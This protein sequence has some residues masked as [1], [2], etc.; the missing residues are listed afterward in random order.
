[1]DKKDWKTPPRNASPD[2]AY[3]R[4]T[5]YIHDRIVRDTAR[6]SDGEAELWPVV[7]GRYRLMAARACPWAHRT[8]IARR[9]LGLEG[10]ISLG[11][12]GPTHDA[13]SWVFDLDPDERDPAT[14]LHRLKEAYDNRFPGYP[15]GI[16]VPAI[17][18]VDSKQVVTNWFRQIPVDFNNEWSDYHRD[19]A[20]DLYPENLRDEIDEVADRVYKQ[21]N[22]GVY[23]CGFAG[24]QE[25]YEGA[26]RELWDG[27]NWLE[28]RLGRQ[29]FLVGEHVTLADVYLYP[30]LVRFDPVYYAHFKAS[31]H[32]IAELPNLRG[33]TQELFGLPGFGDTT[34]FTEIKQHYYITHEEVNPTGV[35]PVGPDLS[36]I[37][38]P[39]D[40]DRFGGSPFAAGVTA[41]GPVLAGE[42]VKNPEPFQLALP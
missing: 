33:Y 10:A 5:T 30:T 22:N 27:L 40:R 39:H 21:V 12:A 7:P 13:D 31:R 34:D 20:P 8:V 36:W 17:V 37:A 6:A 41:P 14:G 32:K 24:S 15:K 4:D 42:E 26:Y 9:L 11:L 16:T 23:R 19:G 28:E 1:M 18:E 29:R 35:V 2:G 38:E 3:V 25:A